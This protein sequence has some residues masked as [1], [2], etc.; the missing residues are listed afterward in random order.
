MAEWAEALEGI[1][2]RCNHNQ[3]VGCDPTRSQQLAFYHSLRL[4]ELAL[5]H[6]CAL[7]RDAAWERFL[8]FYREPLT[9][10]AIAIA[11]SATLGHELADSLYAELFGLST[12]EGEAGPERRSPLASYSGRGSLLG[13]L[14]TTLSQRHIDH[15]RRTH[16]ESPLEMVEA[17]AAAAAP[18]TCPVPGE[19]SRLTEAVTKTLA[20]LDPES[21]FLLAAYFLDRQTLLQ[22]ARLLHV[23]EA[24]VSRKLKR[25]TGDL[26][27]QLLRHLQTDG[28]NGEPPALSRRAA[29]EALGTDPRDLEINLRRLLQ[30]SQTAPFSVQPEVT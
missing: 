16:R 28:P 18:A 10:A 4:P 20:G 12:R 9:H 15:H 17:T 19:L 2:A 24:T 11:G 14:R 7:G 23:H 25:L 21:R 1:G 6:A 26:R 27:K 22:I 8:A 13:W 29:E 5:A 30:P 3:P